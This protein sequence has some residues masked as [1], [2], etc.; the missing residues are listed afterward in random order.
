MVNLLQELEAI[1][2]EHKDFFDK[3]NIRPFQY[4]SI[5]KKPVMIRFN[6]NTDAV[7]KLPKEAYEKLHKLIMSYYGL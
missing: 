5:S 1:E 4:V 7:F 6:A 2:N 3:N